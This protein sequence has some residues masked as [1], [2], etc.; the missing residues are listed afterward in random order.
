MRL[1]ILRTTINY[2]YEISESQNTEGAK[3][4]LPR[5]ISLLLKVTKYIYSSPESS[6]H[7][8]NCGP[9]DCL[10]GFRE[11]PMFSFV[12]S[13]Q[14]LRDSV[15]HRLLVFVTQSVVKFDGRQTGAQLRG[16]PSRYVLLSVT[17]L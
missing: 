5:C 2:C 14:N 8:A 13:D 9:A 3:L 15:R 1:L 11:E 17:A 10:E 16:F 6:C 7:S 4:R 12:Q